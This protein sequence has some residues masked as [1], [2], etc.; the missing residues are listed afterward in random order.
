VVLVLQVLPLALQLRQANRTLPIAVVDRLAGPL[1]IAAHKVGEAS[2]EIG[3]FYLAEILG[4]REYLDEVHYRK[5]GRRFFFHSSGVPFHQRPEIGLTK[6]IAPYAYNFDRGL[7]ESDLRNKVT[8]GGVDLLEGCSI[9]DISLSGDTGD[10]H[11]IVYSRHGEPNRVLEARWVVDAMGRRRFLQ[12]RLNLTKPNRKRYSAAWFRMA[13]RIDISDFVSK[14]EISWHDRV[15][16]HSRYDA[17]NH[18]CG[19]GY[20]VWIIRLSSDH[21]SIGLVADEKVHPF[22]SYNSYPRLYRWLQRHEPDLAHHLGD[23]KPKDFKKMPR[24]SYSAKQIFSSNRW[25]CVGEAATFTDPLYGTGTDMIG[26]ANCLTT[27]LIEKDLLN[28]LDAEAVDQANLFFLSFNDGLA[29][30]IM[31]AYSCF[32]H[33]LSMAMKTIWD[34]MAGWAFTAPML[35]NSLYV[36]TQFR[37][38]LWPDAGKFFLLAHRVQQLFQDWAASNVRRGHFEFIDYLALPFVRE[39]R[40]RNLQSGQTNEELLA[41]HRKNIESFE[42]FAQV[43]FLLALEDTAPHKLRQLAPGLWLNAWGISLDESRWRQDRLFSPDTEPRDLQPMWDLLRSRIHF[44]TA[45]DTQ[46]E[47][48]PAIVEAQPIT[49]KYAAPAT[50]VGLVV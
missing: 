2:T 29:D 22:N 10:R 12:K 32:G 26:L 30:N 23:R 25:A 50:L 39:L 18:L 11:K 35:F 24:Y 43:I 34:T 16:D 49:E 36:D 31:T 7:L 5:F 8:A 41:A 17:T 37:Q 21:T 13:G 45:S 38:R 20:W 19:P 15:V 28:E 27:Q 9:R 33:S 14:S 6:Y 46:T 4:L 44:A 1:P 40:L 3:S 48:L 42:E 47:A